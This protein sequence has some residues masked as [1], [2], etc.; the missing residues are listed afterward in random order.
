MTSL[1]LLTAEYKAVEA[2]LEAMDLDAQTIADTLESVSGDFEEKAINVAMFIRNLE[3][4]AAAIKQAESDMSDRRKAQE[5]KAQV[6]KEYLKD[7]MQA[8]GKIKIESPYFALTIKKNPSAVVIDV[9]GAIP[10]ELYTYPVA[11]EPFPDK[12]AIADLLK[13]GEEVYGCHLENGTRLDIK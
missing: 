9:A 4:S 3:A 12:K 10:S 1:Y 13:A 6:M 5:K 7:N 11:P 2:K 8:C